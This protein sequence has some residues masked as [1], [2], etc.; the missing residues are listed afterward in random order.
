[1]TEKEVVALME[2]SKTAREWD[3]NCDKVKSVFG[4]YPTFWFPAIL[5][6]GLAKRVLARC[7]SS[8]EIKV[9]AVS[10]STCLKKSV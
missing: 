3:D 5:A 6:S 10:K 1:M 4:G 2:S 8:D 9:G 7:G